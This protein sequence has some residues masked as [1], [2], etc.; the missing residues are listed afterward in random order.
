MVIVKSRER[1]AVLRE[2]E[3]RAQQQQQQQQEQN[4]DL[5]YNLS[6]GDQG[7]DSSISSFLSQQFISNFGRQNGNSLEAATNAVQQQQHPVDSK[8]S[9]QQL[10]SAAQKAA[11]VH[12][13]SAQMQQQNIPV[14]NI[15][16][17]QLQQG[18]VRSMST[19]HQQQLQQT[20]QNAMLLNMVRS[21]SEE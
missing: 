13:L 21:G 5:N 8:L 1:A 10:Q 14:A 2:Q 15:L 16:Q 18:L 3:I 12:N 11:L 17:R 7:I 9:S 4:N 6:T 20:K 19:P